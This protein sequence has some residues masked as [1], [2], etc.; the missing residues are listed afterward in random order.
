MNFDGSHVRHLSHTIIS[1][2][3]EA[4]K[5]EEE[6]EEERFD[7]EANVLLIEYNDSIVCWW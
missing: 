2:E 1:A 5:T 7:A 4:A 6:E 3:I